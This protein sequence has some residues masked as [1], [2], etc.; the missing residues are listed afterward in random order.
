MCINR[1]R[2]PP[3]H[4][5]FT[6]PP[7]HHRQRT[8]PGP[9]PTTGRSQRPHHRQLT[10]PPAHH[11]HRQLTAPPHTTGS[12]QRPHHRQLALGSAPPTTSNIVSNA[13]S[14]ANCAPPAATHYKMPWLPTWAPVSKMHAQTALPISAAQAAAGNLPRLRSQTHRL[15]RWKCCNALV[16][17][18]EVAQ[19]SSA[20]SSAHK[21]NCVTSPTA[22]LQMVVVA[23]ALLVHMHSTMW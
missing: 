15:P 10:A 17:G 3:R 23:K 18:S 6:A 21:H 22:G 14:A 7:P 8:A 13:A 1:L 5:Q 11:R 16:C 4:W 19:I 12:S 9:P 20:S 2:P